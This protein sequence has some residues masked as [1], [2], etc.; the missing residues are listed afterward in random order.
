MILFLVGLYILERMNN[1]T[2]FQDLLDKSKK[3]LDSMP[4]GT[5]INAK[6]ALN[7]F[8][9]SI[10][11][12]YSSSDDS[13]EGD[14]PDINEIINPSGPKYGTEKCAKEVI[15]GKIIYTLP[16]RKCTCNN[17][18]A[19]KNKDVRKNDIKG[20]G[21]SKAKGKP[22]RKGKVKGKDNNK[23]S[24]STNEGEC[25][26]YCRG[27][28]TVNDAQVE[29][30]NSEKKEKRVHKSL[31]N[32]YQLLRKVQFEGYSNKYVRSWDARIENPYDT[33]TDNYDEA[34]DSDSTNPDDDMN[35]YWEDN[36]S[37]VPKAISPDTIES[38]DKPNAAK[39]VNKD[40]DETLNNDQ[41][42]TTKVESDKNSCGCGHSV[43]TMSR[44]R[45][46]SGDCCI[47]AMFD[48]ADKFEYC[49]PGKYFQRF[50]ITKDNIRS[51]RI[52]IPDNISS[53]I[54]G[55]ADLVNNV[56]KQNYSP[57]S[58]D[59]ASS[60]YLMTKIPSEI[61]FG[62]NTDIS[63]RIGGH[64]QHL[65][66]KGKLPND[67]TLPD[68][69]RLKT[70]VLKSACKMTQ[71]TDFFD[72]LITTVI[73]DMQP[74]STKVLENYVNDK[75][76][77]DEIHV[78]DAM[79]LCQGATIKYPAMQN[80][81]TWIIVCILRKLD[82]SKDV[83]NAL[84]KIMMYM[85]VKLRKGLRPAVEYQGLKVKVYTEPENKTIIF[86]IVVGF[87]NHFINKILPV[88]ITVF[89]TYLN[90]R[91]SLR[92]VTYLEELLKEQIEINTSFFISSFLKLM[93]LKD[94]WP[95][96]MMDDNL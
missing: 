91:E 82:Y 95:E 81:F 28:S 13:D 27:K 60:Y 41:Q 92:L 88:T 56:I 53:T 80:H 66:D 87:L 14:P 67:L 11:K 74:S 32:K 83:K 26:C 50:T 7:C 59:S 37:D 58:K 25:N 89:L 19:E 45:R 6:L 73:D 16:D 4:L 36:V 54:Y 61:L 15:D 3:N 90:K 84:R 12:E 29:E 30:E 34:H 65:H 35:K 51:S 76:D 38:E 18:D 10:T 63:K 55:A 85:L 70:K 62:E 48:E 72:T 20:K 69:M 78:V 68:A 17:N 46:N 44:V 5:L 79:I 42:N 71:C 21:R 22:K 52:R 64:I 77:A 86:I 39:Q 75:P 33:D 49:C 2:D 93:S 94:Y 8:V 47:N 23:P 24:E 31:N 57:F 43:I 40:G 9:D 1:N 96:Q